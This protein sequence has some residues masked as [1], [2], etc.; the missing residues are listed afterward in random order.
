MPGEPAPVPPRRSMIP[1]GNGADLRGIVGHR[2]EI[3][4]DLARDGAGPGGRRH[5][6]DEVASK[7]G[8]RGR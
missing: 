3:G 8:V 2:G 5:P 7:R 6:V 4:V 1:R